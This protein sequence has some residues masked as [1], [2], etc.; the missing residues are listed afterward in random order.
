MKE[1]KELYIM[2]GPLGANKTM[3][4]EAIAKLFNMEPIF[5][6][7]VKTESSKISLDT[8]K[9]ALS[10]TF[11]KHS[12]IILDGFPTNKA[13]S[14]FLL[15]LSK[16]LGYS[17]KCV[18]QLNISLERIV[19]NLKNRFICNNC[20][21]FYEDDFTINKSKDNCPNCG[22]ILTKYHTNKK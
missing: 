5:W 4:S 18:I 11:K 1:N 22:A 16:K 8:L 14:L 12:R 2:I 7:K 9:K 3:Y 20:G 6:G 10:Q 13:E 21:V 19:T 17:I 15:D